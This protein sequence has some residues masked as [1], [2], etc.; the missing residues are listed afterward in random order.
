MRPRFYILILYFVLMSACVFGAGSS[1]IA[2]S[3][4]NSTVVTKDQPADPA[5]QT[6]QKASTGFG[7]K[8]P[9]TLS[10]EERY[11]DLYSRYQEERQQLYL[12]LGSVYVK[13]KMFDAAIKSYETVL[14]ID[15]DNTQAHYSLGIVYHQGKKDRKN[16]IKH[17]KQY[18]KF[19]PSKKDRTEAEFLIKML[20]NE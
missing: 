18:I 6:E 13:A 1:Q 10:C 12:E 15:P 11:M 8:E 4:D 17:L 5:S 16:A 2:W 9:N 19:A 7:P 20:E 14:V 3:E